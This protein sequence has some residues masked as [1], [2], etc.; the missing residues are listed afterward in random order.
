MYERPLTVCSEHVKFIETGKIS[1]MSHV[2]VVGSKFYLG[3]RQ[4][5]IL[6]TDF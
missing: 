3:I 5:F 4:N 2:T 6:L 1:F